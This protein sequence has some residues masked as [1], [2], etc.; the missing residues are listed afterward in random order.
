MGVI[1]ATRCKIVLATFFTHNRF[2]NFVRRSQMHDEVRFSLQNL[3]AVLAHEL[4]QQFTAQ[5]YKNAQN[6][7]NNAQ[8]L[9]KVIH[10]I[11]NIHL[12]W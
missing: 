2:A 6:S 11:T 12:F 1:A 8:T 9:R 4:Q 10:L 5:Y 7:P 3:A